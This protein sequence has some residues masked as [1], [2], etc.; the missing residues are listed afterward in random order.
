MVR[1]F[2]SQQVLRYQRLLHQMG[3]QQTEAYLWYFNEKEG[4]IR[5]TDNPVQGKLF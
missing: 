4:L 5:V 1:P 2:L 3:Y